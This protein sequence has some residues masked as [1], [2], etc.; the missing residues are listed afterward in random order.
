MLKKTSSHD[1]MNPILHGLGWTWW[2]S[3][4]GLWNLK[5]KPLKWVHVFC[6][7]CRLHIQF[8]CKT[9]DK[10]QHIPF[11]FVPAS[12][13][14]LLSI[15]LV[16]YP[17]WKYLKYFRLLWRWDSF[18]DYIRVS[19]CFSTKTILG[20]GTL[21]VWLQKTCYTGVSLRVLVWKYPSTISWIFSVAYGIWF[22]WAAELWW[23]VKRNTW[24]SHL[25]PRRHHWPPFS[26]SFC[27]GFLLEM[28][29][30]WLCQPPL[31][32]ARTLLLCFL[33]SPR[34]LKWARRVVNLSCLK[35]T[36]TEPLNLV[37][38][39]AGLSARM[40]LRASWHLY[41]PPWLAQLLP[42]PSAIATFW[43]S[44]GGL[45]PSFS[46]WYHMKQSSEPRHGDHREF[47]KGCQGQ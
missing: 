30:H 36:H 14:F 47:D 11:G 42:M 2:G 25:H 27:Q 35:L 39:M 38:F 4:F 45:W 5:L 46:R 16:R 41:A 1:S 18:F 22:W 23:W 43:P 31:E 44:L 37:V 33:I 24:E 12:T 28:L 20:I 29:F 3:I 17:K 26:A 19:L 9:S 6:Q 8:L 40:L 34:R 13:W 7:S 15:K 21:E 10:K 32:G